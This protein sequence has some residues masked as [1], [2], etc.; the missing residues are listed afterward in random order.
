MSHSFWNTL[1]FQMGQSL[2]DG[3]SNLDLTFTLTIMITYMNLMSHCR[4]VGL[5]QVIL[6]SRWIN[7]LSMLHFTTPIETII[8]P[9]CYLFTHF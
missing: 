2:W 5:S 1:L 9:Y 6:S 4:V 3:G 8:R 7:L